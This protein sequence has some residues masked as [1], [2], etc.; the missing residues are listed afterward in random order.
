ML[1]KL[2]KSATGVGEQGFL[3]ALSKFAPEEQQLGEG[4]IPGLIDFLV[5]IIDKCNQI[6]NLVNE[7]SNEVLGDMSACQRLQQRYKILT[8]SLIGSLA[9]LEEAGVIEYQE[10]R[11]ELQKWANRL[12][13]VTRKPR[14]RQRIKPEE[15]QGLIEDRLIDIGYR[16]QDISNDLIPRLQSVVRQEKYKE[17]TD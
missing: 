5:G 17:S 14:L 6:I 11:R 12:S 1:M 3:K 13:H 15:L 8:N 7:Q 16:L 10:D 9:L 4:R 2:L